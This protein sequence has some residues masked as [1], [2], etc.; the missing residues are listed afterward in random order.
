MGDSF[1]RLLL[2]A[3]PYSTPTGGSLA[4][5]PG[6]MHYRFH[7]WEGAHT[8]TWPWGAK[9]NTCGG[10]AVCFVCVTPSVLISGA[11]T[12]R[13]CSLVMS[14]GAPTDPQQPYRLPAN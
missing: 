14:E 9:R 5:A 11:P 12:L 7:R 8:H 2:E 1:W 4:R 3:Q 13:A 6:R 10:G